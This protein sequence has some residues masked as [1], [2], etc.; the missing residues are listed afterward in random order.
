LSVE[1]LYHELEGKV[2]A[3]RPSEDLSPLQEAYQFAAEHHI[4][5][6]RDSGEPYLVHPLHVTLILA[7]MQMDM[8]CLQTGL[9]HDIVEDTTVTVEEIRK[10]FGAEVSRCVDCWRW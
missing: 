10:K 9:L 8:V 7:E 2:R 4:D 3:L 6:K 5:Q 1:Q